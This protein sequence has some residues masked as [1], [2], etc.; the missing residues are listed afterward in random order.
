MKIKSNTDIYHNNCN[1]III[2]DLYLLYYQK[3]RSL[4]RLRAFDI[5]SLFH[6][7]NYLRLDIETTGI[8]L[9]LSRIFDIF[10]WKEWREFQNSELYVEDQKRRGTNCVTFLKLWGRERRQRGKT[11]SGRRAEGMT[12]GEKR[13][14]DAEKKILLARWGDAISCLT[15]LICS[16]WFLFFPLVS[17]LVIPPYCW[18]LYACPVRLHQV[19]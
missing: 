16:Y 11:K 17:F 1:K 8:F 4:I 15:R 5:Q 19:Q 14:E 10:S 13:E 12:V 6:V 7:E 9:R 18:Q 3:Y 2:I